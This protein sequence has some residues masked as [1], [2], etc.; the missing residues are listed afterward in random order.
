MRPE[1]IMKNPKQLLIALSALALAVTPTFAKAQ[2]APYT[3]GHVRTVSYHDRTPH[4]HEHT[5]VAHH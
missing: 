3:S 2:R 1:G 4:A 5:S